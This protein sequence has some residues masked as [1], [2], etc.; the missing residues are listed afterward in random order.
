MLQALYTMRQT[1]KHM[2]IDFELNGMIIPPYTLHDQGGT[3]D[4]SYHKGPVWQNVWLPS[5]KL[6]EAAVCEK[7]R[8]VVSKCVRNPCYVVLYDSI[9]ESI[10]LEMTLS[11]QDFPTPAHRTPEWMVETPRGS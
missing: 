6:V 8:C 7:A 2:N 4:N 1:I 9:R 3:A 5:S 11:T 10:Y